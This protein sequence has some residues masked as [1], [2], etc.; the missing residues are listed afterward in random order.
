[1][2]SALQDVSEVHQNHSDLPEKV[3]PGGIPRQISTRQILNAAEKI[4]SRDGFKGAS[5]TAIAKEAKLPK[6]NIHYYFKT[7]E[8]LF[9][10]T[11]EYNV[12]AWL[13]D[14]DHWF[15]TDRHPRDA[16]TGYIRA[17]LRHAHDNPDASRLFTQEMLQGAPHLH[18]YL[19]TELRRHVEDRKIIFQTWTEK[20]LMAETD[21]AH[22]MFCLWSITQAYADTGLQLALVLGQE[23]LT[24]HDFETAARTLA[25]IIL[26]GVL[27]NAIPQ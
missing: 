26:V 8:D 15:T 5:M 16:F 10:A 12:I 7:K 1:M 25:D 20:G 9:R 11:L 21:A 24:E 13:S 27:P 22:L 18:H 4:F 23:K 14:A 19:S 17:K 2:S 3:L 6:A